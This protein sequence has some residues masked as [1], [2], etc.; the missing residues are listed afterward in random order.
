MFVPVCEPRLKESGIARGGV[1]WRGGRGGEDMHAYVEKF[2]VQFKRS[3]R[4]TSHMTAKK[5]YCSVR[6]NEIS[7]TDWVHRA[8][9]LRRLDGR[10]H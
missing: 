8:A 2:F 1:A 6:G 5:R 4:H 10:V 9:L 3:S 7:T